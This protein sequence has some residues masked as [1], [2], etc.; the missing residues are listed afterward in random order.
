[1]E[2]HPID[3]A[4]IAADDALLTRIS[5]DSGLITGSAGSAGIAVEQD[6]TELEEL[7]VAWRNACL[8]TS[9]SP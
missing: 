5:A 7:L 3:L 4:A 9:V 2:D 8:A 6:V 1:M